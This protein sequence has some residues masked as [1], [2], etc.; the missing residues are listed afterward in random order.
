MDLAETGKAL[1]QNGRLDKRVTFLPLDK[2]DTS[3]LNH[4]RIKEARRQVGENN[5]FLAKDLIEYDPELEPAMQ[6]IFGNVLV[7]FLKFIKK[8]L[9]VL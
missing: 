4:N 1:L 3:G 6:H 7:C 8:Y 5:V 2:I 9:E